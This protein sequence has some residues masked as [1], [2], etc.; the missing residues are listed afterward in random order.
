MYV[1]VFSYS[2]SMPSPI[3]VVILGVGWVVYTFVMAKLGVSYTIPL[4]FH[5]HFPT[6]IGR[7]ELVVTCSVSSAF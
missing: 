7:R 4:T 6:N 3:A 5:T 2:Q 1:C